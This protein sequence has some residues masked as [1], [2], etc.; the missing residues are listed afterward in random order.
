M[1]GANP[2]LFKIWWL[3]EPDISDPLNQI[4]VLCFQVWKWYVKFEWGSIYAP[5]HLRPGR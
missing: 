3:N 5:A 2:R 4:R 1:R